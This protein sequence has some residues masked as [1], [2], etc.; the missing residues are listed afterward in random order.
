M[1]KVHDAASAAG[2]TKSMVSIMRNPRCYLGT[3]AI[4]FGSEKAIE[5][6]FLNND[7]TCPVCICS[8]AAALVRSVIELSMSGKN[9]FPTHRRGVSRA[10]I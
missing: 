3:L 2:G 9:H 1:A 8:T 7:T 4:A 5:W 10:E 6:E